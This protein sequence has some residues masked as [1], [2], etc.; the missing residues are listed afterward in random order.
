[1]R[2]SG[3]L[4]VVVCKGERPGDSAGPC[5]ALIRACLPSCGWSGLNLQ[6]RKRRDNRCVCISV[7]VYVCVRGVERER[8]GPALKLPF[9]SQT[10][11][12]RTADP[13][14]PPSPS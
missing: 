14:L 13:S 11:S 5:R 6:L 7:C 10:N 4:C 2:W 9:P 12:D 3:S 8:L 1:M